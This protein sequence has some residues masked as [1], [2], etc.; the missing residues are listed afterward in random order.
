M[1]VL[2]VSSLP[3]IL[4]LI[5][6]LLLL[7]SLKFFLPSFS[8]SYSSSDFSSL[9]LW[10]LFIFWG[11]FYHNFLFTFSLPLPL[12][13]FS[14]YLFLFFFALQSG[15]K[16]EPYSFPFLNTFLEFLRH[17]YVCT[18]R[19]CIHHTHLTPYTP[20]S[21]AQKEEVRKERIGGGEEEV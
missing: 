5:I 4:L 2:T 13:V 1:N 6:I 8:F 15:W 12:V 7:A 11:T 9:F 17:S 3:L 14:V 16:T 19:P 18:R 10:C 21:L 20:D